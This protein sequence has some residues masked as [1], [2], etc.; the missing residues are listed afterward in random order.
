MRILILLLTSMFLY[1]CGNNNS[2][3]DYDDYDLETPCGCAGFMHKLEEE[4][5]TASIERSTEL[6]DMYE[7]EWDHCG[8]VIAVFDLDDLTTSQEDSTNDSYT[9]FNVGKNG[10]NEEICIT[11]Y[12]VEEAILNTDYFSGCEEVAIK[13]A[14]LIEYEVGE[15]LHKR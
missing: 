1:S 4:A 13:I 12:A 9:C 5:D 7:N 2:A 11:D 3:T 10:F 6:E 8:K 15:A 14:H